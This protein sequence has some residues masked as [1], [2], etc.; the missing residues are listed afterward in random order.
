MQIYINKRSNTNECY[1]GGI[2]IVAANSPEEAHEVMAKDARFSYMFSMWDDI[3]NEII[4]DPKDYI[5]D[6]YPKDKWELLLNVT[7]NIDEPRVIC[8]EGYTE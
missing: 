7:T 6:Y 2:A 4:D 3:N 5:N 1:T 8:E